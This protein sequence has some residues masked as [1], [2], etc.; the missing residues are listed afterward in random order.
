VEKIP[1]FNRSERVNLLANDTESQ[2]PSQANPRQSRDEPDPDS[3]ALGKKDRQKKQKKLDLA[4]FYQDRLRQELKDNQLTAKSGA[5]A[6]T[7]MFGAPGSGGVG[8]GTASPFGNRFGYYEQLLRERVARFWKTHEVNASVR[9]APPAIVVFDIMRNGSVRNIRLLQ[10]SGIPA[11]D[12]SCERAIREAA[13]FDALPDGFE[14][15]SANVEFWFQ[16][17]R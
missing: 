8:V 14:R 5:R 1:V 10:S 6:A 13:P 11:L 3:V 16:L 15:D 9:S 2:V 17:K 4:K 12:Y 7:Q